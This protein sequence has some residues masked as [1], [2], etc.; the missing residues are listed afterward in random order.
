MATT[1][2]HDPF[3]TALTRKFL[4]E[5]RRQAGDPGPTSEVADI[6]RQQQQ[7]HTS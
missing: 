4:E 6:V 5:V 3:A 1:P 7:E 2:E